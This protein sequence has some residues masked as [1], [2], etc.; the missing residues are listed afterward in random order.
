MTTDTGTI[1]SRTTGTTTSTTTVSPTQRARVVG[2]LDDADADLLST[3]VLLKSHATIS[4]GSGPGVAITPSGRVITI[5]HVIRARLM[6]AQVRSLFTTPTMP[7]EIRCGE[8]TASDPMNKQK[9]PF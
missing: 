1:H 2:L 8:F 6:L 3:L 5:G 7:N 9:G 4:G